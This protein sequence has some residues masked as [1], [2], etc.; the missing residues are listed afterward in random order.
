MRISRKF[1]IKYGTK[2]S[3]P[4]LSTQSGFALKR[5]GQTALWQQ[6]HQIAKSLSRLCLCTSGTEGQN[7]PLKPVLIPARRSAESARYT[8]PWSIDATR[9]RL[10]G[11]T[12]AP[13]QPP[14]MASNHRMAPF[15]KVISQHAV[16][17]LF[18]YPINPR[19]QYP[20]ANLKPPSLSLSVEM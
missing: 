18:V 16:S 12:L 1:C 3:L 5:R 2:L 14:F 20:E 10:C 6:L 11:P 13:K 7:V 4:S 8:A 17:L 19:S 15:C 9:M